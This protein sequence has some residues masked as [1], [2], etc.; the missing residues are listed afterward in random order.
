MLTGGSPTPAAEPP[1]SAP[2]RLANGLEVVWEEDHRQPLV[3]I[4]ARIRG[5]LRAE[6]AQAGTGITHFIEHLLFKGTPSRPPGTL[7]QEIRRYG[8]TINAFTAL[9]ATGVSLFVESRYLK[10]ALGLLADVLQHAIFDPAEVE[11]ERAVVL[12]EI[13]MNLDDPDRRVHQLLWSRR[14]LVHPYRHPILGYRSLLEQVSVD[15]LVRFYRAQY[16]PQ[17]VVVSLVGDLDGAAVPGLVDEALGGWARGTTDPHQAVV[18]EEPPP[19]AGVSATEEL[20]IQT[21]YVMLG[22]R[23]TRLADPDLYPLDVLASI[24][25][26]GRS[27]RLYHTLVRERRLVD[28]IDAWNYTPW[29]PGIFTI[30]FRTNPEQVDAAADAVLEIARDVQARGVTPGEL[31]KAKKQVIAEYLFQ[32]QTVESKAHDLANSLLATGDPHFSRYYVERI[33]QVTAEDV[34]AAARRYCDAGTM[35]RAVIRPVG[36]TASTAAAPSVGV[37]T[38]RRALAN[39]ATLLLGVDRS[40]PVAAVTVGFRGGVRAEDETTQGLSNLVAQMLTKGTT[41]RSALQIA[42]AVESLGGSLEPYSGRDGFGLSLRLLAEDVEQ[43]VRL[44]HELVT[45]SQFPERELTVQRDLI[46]KQLAAERDEIFRVTG[47][48]LRRTLFGAH[49]YRFNPLGIED[50]VRTFTSKDCQAFAHRWLAPSNLVIAVFGDI[51]VGTVGGQIEKTFGRMQGTA[52]AWPARIEEPPLTR[53]V[54][55]TEPLDREQ[56]VIML[57]FRGTTH[58]AADRHA[59]EVLEAVLSGMD[60]RLFQ[61]VREEHGLAYTLGAVNAPGWDPGYLLVYAATRP[62]EREKVLGLLEQQLRATHEG[63]SEAEVDRAKRT[64]IGQHRLQVQQVVGL[65]QRAVIDELYGVGFDAWRDYDTHMTAVTPALVGEAARRYVTLEERA[66]VI[67]GPNGH[68][69]STQ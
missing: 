24:L 41:K 29:D 38:S 67:V 59:M 14:F 51:E 18:P 56:V 23:S 33:G 30:Y 65:S 47:N 39:G 32:R 63:F 2:L 5:G 49:P 69:T 58:T 7:D 25:G 61:S 26:K 3:A 28:S 60:G 13:Q 64:L 1:P 35:T 8:G 17:H 66:E 11:K 53:V 44:M 55:V 50:T 43:G 6:G 16:Q 52:A 54:S 40:L 31:A 27:A 45:D 15:D 46:I 19:V 9:D 37:A 48:L 10:E 36:A 20:P 62:E 21:A 4:E 34:Q 42:E 12:S 68:R 22:F 57:G